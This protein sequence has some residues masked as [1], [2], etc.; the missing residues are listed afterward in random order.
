MLIKD[1][2]RVTQICN[3]GVIFVVGSL[4]PMD[5]TILFS[6]ADLLYVTQPHENAF[7]L[8]LNIIEYDVCH[9]VI[10]QGSFVDLIHISTYK[11]INLSMHALE[12]PRR[13]LLS[14]NS[15]TTFSLNDIV[16]PIFVSSLHNAILDRPWIHNMKVK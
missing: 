13:A 12:S 3:V 8:M 1:A 6:K 11:Q 9:I 15:S 16:F 10:D 4:V 7:I 5:E 2:K 14:F